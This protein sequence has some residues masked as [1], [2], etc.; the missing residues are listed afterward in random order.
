VKQ[1]F[2]CLVPLVMTA[3][4]LA[5]LTSYWEDS[6]QQEIFVVEGDNYVMRVAT[7]PARILSLR[8]GGRDTLGSGGAMPWVESADKRLMPA[9]KEI[10]PDWQVHTGQRMKPAKSSRARMNVWRASPHYWEIHLR[11][12]PFVPSDADT[13]PLRGHLVIHAHPD[14]AHV[15]LRF[16]PVDGQKPVTAGWTTSVAEA[17]TD[18][19]KGRRTLRTVDVGVLAPPGGEFAPDG[20]EWQAP[21]DNAWWVVRPVGEGPKDDQLFAAETDP[22]SSDEFTAEDGLWTG[23]DAGSG[24]YVL[25]MTAHRAAF[26]F[27]NAW[28]VPSRRMVTPVTVPTPS[29][30]RRITVMA[31]TGT[32]NLEAGA[33][34]DPHGFPR[35]IPTFVTK[36]FA[37]EN[38]EPEDRAFGDIIFPLQVGPKSPREH[39]VIGLYQTWG[40]LMLKQVSSI[41]FFNIYWHLSTGLSETTCFTHAWMDIRDTL[42]SIPDFRPFSGPFIMGQPQHDCFSWPGFLNY[43]TTNGTVRPMY[44]RT[45]FHS[46]APCLAHFTMHFR[47]GD[48]TADMT[49]EAWEIPQTDEARTFLRVRYSWDKLAVVQGDARENFRWLQMFEKYPVRDFLWLDTDGK[50]RTVPAKPESKFP[51]GAPLAA[52]WPYAGAHEGRS[53]FGTLMLVTRFEGQ[54]GGRKLTRVHATADFNKDS[55][56]YAFTT[57]DESLTLTPGDYLEADV[58]LMPHG[59]V[60]MPFHKPNREREHWG[61]RPP[62]VSQVTRGAKLRDFP[63]TV[64]AENDAAVLRVTGGLNML[65]L[66][67]E[68]FSKRAVP[69]LWK[70]GLWQDQQQEGGDGYQVDTSPDGTFRFTFNYPIRGTEEHDLVVSQLRSDAA[71]SSLRERNGLPVVTAVAETDFRLDSPALF[72]PGRNEV[73]NGRLISFAGRAKEIAAIPLAVTPSGGSATVDC[74]V[75]NPQKIVLTVEGGARL[76][77]GQRIRGRSYRVTFGAKEQTLH[78]E[79]D[80][81]SFDVPPERHQVLVTTIP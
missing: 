73:A 43:E 11:D 29:Q 6:A 30:P 57:G 72:A 67:V 41:R 56:F 37:G 79:S 23:Y 62:I 3:A 12:I 35:A 32:G 27:E 22:L 31:R 47:T 77:I 53:N 21:A 55:G 39:L 68:G 26:T 40:R 78:A 34:T 65:P 10:V 36:N 13:E 9:P 51:V 80:T 14:R 33:V 61:K 75:W 15:E 25:E 28:K 16:E 1:I 50:E 76:E 60:T 19:A 81:I 66:V 48:D 7:H 24:L 59:E 69:L 49:V 46:V 64:R 42:V 17:S 38:E 8:C 45:D 71:V 18:S 2:L 74:A 44:R 58:L 54:L 5:A 63:A 52:Q 70:D 4:Q 20:S